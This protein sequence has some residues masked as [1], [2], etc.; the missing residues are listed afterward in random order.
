V[1]YSGGEKWIRV[2]CA[3]RDGALVVAVTDHGIGIDKTDLDKVFEKFYRARDER[4]RETRGSG[5]G[6]AIVKHSVEAHGGTIA[7]VS[8]QGKGSTFTITLPIRQTLTDGKDPR[9]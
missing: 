4:V 7:V 1:K 8:E 6:L 3:E 9:G 5:L 2:T